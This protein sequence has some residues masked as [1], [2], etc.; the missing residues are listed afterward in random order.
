MPV[1][2]NYLVEPNKPKKYTPMPAD[3][4]QVMIYDVNP[5][6]EL[7]F[8][9]DEMVD[10][11]E[12]VFIV[13]DDK[14]FESIDDKGEVKEET[15]R[16]RKLW[17]KIPRSFSPGGKFKASL[18]FELMCAVERKTLTKEDLV[19]VNPNT[20]IGQ[21][22]AVFVSIN[23]TWNNIDSFLPVKKDLEPMTT[24]LDE[25]PNAV[26]KVFAEPAKEEQPKTP[27][28]ENPANPDDFIAGLE[29]DQKKD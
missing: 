22:L 12:F 21:Q 6:Q 28:T 1:P 26:A 5:I 20:L 11:L 18:F 2:E 7:S 3:K 13:L 8:K 24:I 23:D 16:G 14:K 17:R 29:A 10:K 25:D 19:A 9:G 4:Y 15:T 27:S